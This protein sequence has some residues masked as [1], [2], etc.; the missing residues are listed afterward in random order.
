MASEIIG[1][2]PCPE[3]GFHAAHVKIKT[4]KADAKPYRHCPG[5]SAQYFTRT[6]EQEQ[7]LRAQIRPG[8]TTQTPTQTPVQTQT[9]HTPVSEAKGGTAAAAPEV[10][11]PPAPAK[12]P[13]YKVVFGVR[14]PA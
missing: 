12:E 13:E 9:P 14:V 3:C 5:C 6:A 1:R 10:K 4:D 8:S 11:A 7:N 2:T